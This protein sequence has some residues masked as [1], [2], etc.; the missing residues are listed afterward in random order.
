MKHE[1]RDVK[2]VTISMDEATLRWV[3]IEAA[4]EGQSV[5]KWI[6]GRLGAQ[7]AME[8]QRAEAIESISAFLRSGPRFELS[9]NGKITI[10]RDEMHDGGR[11]RRF[12]DPAVHSGPSIPE[13]AERRR[14]VAEPSADF[15]ADER[16]R[17]GSE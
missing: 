12:D 6:L 2:N 13:Q 10:D 17:S 3:R 4:K 14:G 7:R 9:E 15:A 8:M 1:I 11:F 16:K 5:S